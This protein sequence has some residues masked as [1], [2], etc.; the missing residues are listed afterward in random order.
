[1][2]QL[3]GREQGTRVLVR[4]PRAD[5]IPVV[6][7][8]WENEADLLGALKD[9]LPHVPRYLARTA[10]ATVLSYV[11]GT[12]LS[13]LCPDGKPV[14]ALH[15][16]DLAQLLAQTTSVRREALPP[17]PSCWP[18]DDEDSQ[19]YLRT[20]M[21]LADRQIRQPSW[22]VYGGLF[23]ALG[24][25]EDVLVHLAE[26]VPAMTRRPYSLLH[27]DL[28]RDNVVVTE[29]DGGP[30]LIAVDWELAT[31]GDPIHDLATHL[32]RMRYPEFQQKSVIAAWSEAVGSVK[33]AAAH[34]LDEDLPH[35]IAFEQA[36][37][38]FPDIIRAAKSLEEGLYQGRSADELL[39]EAVGAA[40]RAL[41]AGAEPLGLHEVP[42]AATVGDVLHRWQ[43]CRS[44]RREVP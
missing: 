37:S 43:V 5:A 16:A 14:D 8:T 20:L 11:E 42:S 2:A 17:L 13:R 27:G 4:V 35:Y 12:S 28:H 32:V 39:D 6:I 29:H 18:R 41:E 36:Q 40:L 3:I 23:M 10:T 25:R 34:G 33:P 44:D 24:I 31:Y 1:M 38:V 30:R 19:G 7:R 21:E 9:L 15:I 26:Y 22:S